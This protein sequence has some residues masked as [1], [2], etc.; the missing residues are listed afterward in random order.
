[1]PGHRHSNYTGHY[2][3]PN[4]F[5]NPLSQ[6]KQPFTKFGMVHLPEKHLYKLSRFTRQIRDE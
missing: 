3:Q 6:V 2:A 5:H 1:M 4:L